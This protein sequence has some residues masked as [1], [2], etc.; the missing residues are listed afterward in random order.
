MSGKADGGTCFVASVDGAK[1]G[2]TE[3]HSQAMKQK[4]VSKG[5][6]TIVAV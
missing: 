4:S 6:V 3:Y 2:G 5:S 1:K